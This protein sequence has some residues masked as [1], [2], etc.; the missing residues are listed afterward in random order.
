M[1][2]KAKV[3]LSRIVTGHPVTFAGRGFV[4]LASYIHMTDLMDQMFPSVHKKWATEFEDFNYWQD[5]CPRADVDLPDL[6]PPSSPALRAVS[7]T[8]VTSRLSR[9][10]N[11]SLR[12]SSLNPAAAAAANSVVRDGRKE[13]CPSPLVRSV[14]PDNWSTTLADSASES[15]EDHQHARR[16][17]SFDSMRGSLT[18]WEY[19]GSE[20][21]E[22]DEKDEDEGDDDGDDD[23][24]GGVEQ[25]LDGNT[26]EEMASVPFT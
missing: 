21:E 26:L 9:L 22:D 23:E 14:V 10:H 19:G 24:H 3:I 18:G 2:G 17:L 11:F 25:V 7:D 5:R 16:K 20:G 6:D 4:L 8:S 12:S 13:V 15:E 1:A